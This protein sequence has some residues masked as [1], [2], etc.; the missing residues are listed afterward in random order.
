MS[1]MVKKIV[2][3]VWSSIPRESNHDSF[4][5]HIPPGKR[6]QHSY[7]KSPVLLGK[8]TIFMAMFNSKL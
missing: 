1:A 2:F 4:I 5:N 3:W 7:G 8:S 6:L